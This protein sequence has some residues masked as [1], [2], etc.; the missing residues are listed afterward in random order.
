M[1]S[2]KD[3]DTLT[4]GQRVL[5]SCFPIPSLGILVRTLVSRLEQV[6]GTGSII[7]PTSELQYFLATDLVLPP[8]AVL[9]E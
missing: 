1:H 7:I 2:M 3:S 5:S 6:E 8:A 4:E 9:N